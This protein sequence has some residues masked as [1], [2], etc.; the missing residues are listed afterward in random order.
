MSEVLINDK[1]F[2]YGQNKLQKKN[3]WS[4]GRKL[5]NNVITSERKKCDA[6]KDHWI[7]NKRIKYKLFISNRK[8]SN[9]IINVI[10]VITIKF[11]FKMAPTI[12]FRY[13]N[14]IYLSISRLGAGHFLGGGGEGS[15]PLPPPMTPLLGSGP[16]KTSTVSETET[17]VSRHNGGPI[18]GTASIPQHHKCSHKWDLKTAS[19]YF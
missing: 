13:F 14:H 4:H 18:K 19:G 11:W 10:I 2:N 7:Q 5:Q 8:K 12:K 16:K 17:R 15:R 3:N 1:T 9:L 6:K